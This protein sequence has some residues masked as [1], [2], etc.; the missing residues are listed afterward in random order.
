MKPS[1]RIANLKRKI[2]QMEEDWPFFVQRIADYTPAQKESMLA[3]RKT[4][5]DE[6]ARSF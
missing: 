6:C 3:L 5:L 4:S 1:I 2:R